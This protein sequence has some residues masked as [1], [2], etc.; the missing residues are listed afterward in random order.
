V[1]LKGKYA[2]AKIFAN[3]CDPSAIA[4][5]VELLN[6]PFTEGAT[7]RVMP[8][9]HAG[10]GCTIGTTIKLAEGMDKIVPNLIG[11]DIGCGMLW[12]EIDL[13]EKDLPEI[14]EKIRASVP[15]GFSVREYPWTD[16]GIKHV[17]SL[18]FKPEELQTIRAEK[19]IGTL[20]GGNHFI[21][22]AKSQNT[23][24]YY[25]I[26]H[27]GSRGIGKIVADYHQR[28]A[29][30]E[31]VGAPRHLAFLT[32][33]SSKEYQRDQ[34]AM[35][36]FAICN[37]DAIMEAIVEATDGVIDPMMY[38]LKRH[39]IH[40][41]IEKKKT[42]TIRK[43]AVSAKL[44]ERILIPMNMGF[45]SLVC[46]GLGNEEWNCSA[47]HGAGRNFSRSEAKRQINIESFKESMSGIFSTSV[48][49]STI[50]ESPMAY[51]NPLDIVS[52]IGETCE[53]VDVLNPVYNFKASE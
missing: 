9:V 51:K 11:V 35:I 12:K 16:I 8:D 40:N 17:D 7:I 30:K 13:D 3:K 21:E 2:I 46:R 36:G 41:Y 38:M 50:D 14:D 18:S 31:C 43:G 34:G 22:I 27:S 19:S 25:L 33:D 53:I 37:R 26:I 1:I 42:I 49:Q 47:P 4:Q 6:Q 52:V 5:I 24:K 45:G 10:A 48:N 44:E 28:M 15:S 39:T 20:G 29:Q 32:G 23:G